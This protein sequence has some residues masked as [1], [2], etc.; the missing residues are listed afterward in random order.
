[1]DRPKL[2][3]KTPLSTEERKLA[4]P[5]EEEPRLEAITKLQAALTG[6]SLRNFLK[7]PKVIEHM[8]DRWDLE[9]IRG[10]IHPCQLE[11]YHCRELL[12]WLAEEGDS[13]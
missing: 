3:P 13:L 11:I 5:I 10:V 8:S 2:R 1:M 6:I 4:Y 12:V 7:H 9:S